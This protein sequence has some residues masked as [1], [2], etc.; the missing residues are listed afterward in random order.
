MKVG[1]EVKE[2][3]YDINCLADFRG[4]DELSCLVPIR[5]WY[6]W[7]IPT[8]IILH[9]WHF[10]LVFRFVHP[11]SQA[12]FITA[13]RISKQMVVKG[14]V[15]IVVPIASKKNAWKYKLFWTRRMFVVLAF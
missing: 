10:S 3:L 9:P 15:P 6:P 5:V 2:Y 13:R 11:V 1:I 8:K 14:Y 4:V 12:S 7:F